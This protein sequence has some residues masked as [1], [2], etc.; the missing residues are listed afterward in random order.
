MKYTGDPGE[1]SLPKAMPDV[2]GRAW[3]RGLSYKGKTTLGGRK[4]GER[5][6]ICLKAGSEG[7]PTPS[8][9]PRG[10]D[11]RNCSEGNE[12]FDGRSK[13]KKCSRPQARG[14]NA[15]TSHT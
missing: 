14:K 2:E 7:S 11:T 5:N 6:A 13:N 10:K 9:S 3:Q 1:G 8:G 15:G 4:K 12:A